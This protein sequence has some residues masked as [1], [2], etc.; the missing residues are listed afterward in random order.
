MAVPTTTTNLLA[1][2]QVDLSVKTGTNEDWVD[3][4][5]FLID[6]GGGD[7]ADFPQLDLH[8]IE[9]LMEVRR[10]TADNEV[11]FRAST[12]DSTLVVGDYPNEGHLII[13]VDHE[14]MKQQTP[15]LYFADIV[16][17]EAP[18]FIRRCVTINLEIVQ[19][20]TRP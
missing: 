12:A 8:G 6:D 15:G 3:S 1:M 7:E 20:V 17:I 9:F 5:L 14:T 11:V 2:P 13:N 18:E 10:R 4:I 16:G 19:G